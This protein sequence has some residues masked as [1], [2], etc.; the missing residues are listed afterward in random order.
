MVNDDISH[1]NGDADEADETADYE[2]RIDMKVRN[3]IDDKERTQ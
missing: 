1:G 2:E 3:D